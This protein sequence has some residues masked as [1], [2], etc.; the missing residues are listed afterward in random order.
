M[1]LQISNWLSPTNVNLEFYAHDQAFHPLPIHIA[2]HIQWM[3]RQMKS[4]PSPLYYSLNTGTFPLSVS[5]T[6][7][8]TKNQPTT[9]SRIFPPEFLF[10]PSNIIS[11]ADWDE[12][13]RAMVRAREQYMRHA[14]SRGGNTAQSAGDCGGVSAQ[15]GGL[16]S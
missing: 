14:P 12:V 10:I 8:P 4:N 6:T 2:G 9:M 15:G 7:E 13:A 16:Q 3:R 11:K 1:L 5:T